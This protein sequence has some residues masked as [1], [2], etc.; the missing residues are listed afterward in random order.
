MATTGDKL[1]WNRSSRCESGTCVEVAVTDDE[2]H[3]RQAD[4]HGQP[5]TFS[6]QTWRAFTVAARAGSFDLD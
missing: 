3:V 2:V 6:R 1:S 4:G 5:L